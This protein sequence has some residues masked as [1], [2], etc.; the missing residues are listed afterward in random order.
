MND[1]KI[2]NFVIRFEKAVL[3]AI[4]ESDM[5]RNGGETV[6]SLHEEFSIIIINIYTAILFN[7]VCM[8][9]FL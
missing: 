2:I 5:I 6:P 3:D 7:K 1:C 8:Q 4:I 9:L